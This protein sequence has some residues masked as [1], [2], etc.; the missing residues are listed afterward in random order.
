[1]DSPGT[2]HP[3]EP[4]PDHASADASRTRRALRLADADQMVRELLAPGRPRDRGSNPN[5]VGAAGPS[6]SDVG[7]RVRAGHPLQDATERVLAGMLAMHWAGTLETSAVR[8][9]RTGAPVPH[10]DV[11]QVTTASW[12]L[13]GRLPHG[14]LIL[15]TDADLGLYRLARTSMLIDLLTALLPP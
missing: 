10:R 2:F 3:P 9:H 12:T 1:M 15:L 11:V 8:V 7:L 14:P 13:V 4:G 5:P 6:L